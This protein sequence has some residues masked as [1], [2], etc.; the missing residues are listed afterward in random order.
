MRYG[1]QPVNP[2][3]PLTF[4]LCLLLAAPVTAQTG[5]A[6]GSREWKRRFENTLAFVLNPLGIQ[7]AFDVSWTK[8]TNRSD[9]PLHKDAH[10]AFG[11]SSKLT[12]A[13][14]RVG[15]WFE[16]APLSVLDLRIGIEPV[17]YFGTYKAILPFDRA[18]A[19]FDDDVIEA[20]VK[21]ARSGLA[22]RL[23]LSPT[24]KARVGPVVARVKT[25]LSFW[26]ARKQ[27][28]AFFYEPAWD[29]LIQ[30]SG[31]TLL[32]VEALAL[33]EFKRADGTTV[34]FGPVYDL[35]TVS[36]ASVNRKQDVGLLLVWA[37]SRNFHAL[38]DP[39]VAVKAFYFLQDPWR[40]HQAAAQFAFVFGL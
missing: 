4:A 28:S 7:D 37:R 14:E 22:G 32:S 12:P 23:Y 11:V 40:R 29:T 8:P 5:T 19:R 18:A 13:F 39:T 10:L 20:R 31:S 38:K 33:R 9:A 26:R 16:Y 6:S 36:G 3:R 15:A 17:Y 34:L 30:A 24:L 27:E 1:L 35:T 2:H 21:E 25:E